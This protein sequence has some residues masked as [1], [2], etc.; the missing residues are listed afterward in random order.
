MTTIHVH[1]HADAETSPA[2]QIIEKRIAHLQERREA[3]MW[4][5]KID[6]KIGV[7]QS[8]LDE[9][10]VSTPGEEEDE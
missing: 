2:G 1:I 9:F 6:A 4:K 10:I 3:V 7:L 5:D 8:I